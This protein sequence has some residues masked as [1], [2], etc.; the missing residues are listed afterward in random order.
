MN[1]ITLYIIQEQIF[2]Y[3]ILEDKS[4]KKLGFP[5]PFIKIDD[6]KIAKTLDVSYQEIPSKRYRTID[7][8]FKVREGRYHINIHSRNQTTVEKIVVIKIGEGYYYGFQVLN[9]KGKILKQLIN[10]DMPHEI[11][12]IVIERL[13][14]IPNFLKF[15]LDQ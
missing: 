9:L 15:N 6:Y 3:D 13:K 11:K 5:D 1:L 7:K 2:D 4:Y 12:T 8:Q 10:N 14:S